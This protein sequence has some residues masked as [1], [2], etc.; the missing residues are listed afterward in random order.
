MKVDLLISQRNAVV[1]ALA[2]VATYSE[3]IAT[4]R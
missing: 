4:R 1:V 3:M 2:V